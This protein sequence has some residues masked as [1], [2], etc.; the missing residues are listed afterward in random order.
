MSVPVWCCEGGGIS[1]WDISPSL[2]IMESLTPVNVRQLSYLVPLLDHCPMIISCEYTF[3]S[4]EVGIYG[5][6]A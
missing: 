1:P 2:G 4:L 6:A 5:Q 3:S